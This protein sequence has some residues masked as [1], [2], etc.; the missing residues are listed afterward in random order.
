MYYVDANVTRQL[1]A[2]SRLSYAELVG[3]RPVQWFVS[4]WW[5][6]KMRVYCEALQ[7]HA[8]AVSVASDAEWKLALANGADLT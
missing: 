5:G 6:T 3:P 7:R 8:K 1:C 2:P 4:H